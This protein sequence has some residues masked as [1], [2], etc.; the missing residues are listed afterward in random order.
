MHES[1]S[2]LPAAGLRGDEILLE[3]R[4]LAVADGVGAMSS[5]RPFRSALG[6]HAALEEI[7]AGAGRLYDAQVVAACER[8]FAAGRVDLESDAG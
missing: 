6:V 5:H 1:R 3:A 7:R 4:N 8:A 2:H